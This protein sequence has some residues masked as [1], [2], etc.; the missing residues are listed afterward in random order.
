M[1]EFKNVQVNHYGLDCHVFTLQ[2]I[3]HRRIFRRGCYTVRRKNV[4]PKTVR[5][6]SFNRG[7]LEIFT[8]VSITQLMLFQ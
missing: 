2:F 6:S 5:I 1:R 4:Y 7:S 8:S 3:F